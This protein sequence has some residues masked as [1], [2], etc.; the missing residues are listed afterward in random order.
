M[1]SQT[2]TK[3]TDIARLVV[4]LGGVGIG[5][6]AYVVS[7]KICTCSIYSVLASNYFSDSRGESLRR[8]D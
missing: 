5:V 1:N 4:I 7:R 3:Q 6:V 2:K 8:E